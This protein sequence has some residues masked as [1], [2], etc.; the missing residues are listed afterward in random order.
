ME[1]LMNR[2]TVLF[3]YAATQLVSSLPAQTK[4]DSNLPAGTRIFEPKYLK[5]ERAN[6]VD[7]SSVLCR[8]Q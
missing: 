3:F 7:A 5:G 1:S 8:N 2:F 6:R 4:P